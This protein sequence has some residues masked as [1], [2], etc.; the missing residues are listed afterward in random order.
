MTSVMVPVQPRTKSK[1]TELKNQKGI[2]YDVLVQELLVLY[3][4]PVQSD[5]LLIKAPSLR[6][7]K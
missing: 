5:Q 2:T 6:D 3:G 7:E 1:L 4:S